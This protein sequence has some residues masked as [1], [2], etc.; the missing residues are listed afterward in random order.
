MATALKAK[1][2]VHTSASLAA[3]GTVSSSNWDLTTSLGGILMLRMTPAGTL[4]VGATAKVMVSADTTA[5][6]FRQMFLFTSG[7][8]SGTNYD[9]VVEVPPGVMYLRIDWTGGTGAATTC[10]GIGHQLSSIS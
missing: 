3:A 1:V 2:T 8:T 9:F 4:T 10:E 5:G 6:N 7:L